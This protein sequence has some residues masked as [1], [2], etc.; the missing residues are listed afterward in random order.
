MGRTIST[1]MDSR[2]DVA[3]IKIVDN[4]IIYNDITY[5]LQEEWVLRTYFDEAKSEWVVKSVDI[6]AIKEWLNRSPLP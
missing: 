3:T 2:S 5:P 4:S 6:E 1:S